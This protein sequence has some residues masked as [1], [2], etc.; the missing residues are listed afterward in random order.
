MRVSTRS[1][2]AG[3]LALSLAACAQT[4]APMSTGGAAQPDGATDYL[5]DGRGGAWSIT[6]LRGGDV[7]GVIG[8]QQQG[9]AVAIRAQPEGAAACALGIDRRAGTITGGPGCAGAISLVAGALGD[10]AVRAEIGPAV[11]SP[12]ADAT[13]VAYED[14]DRC[15]KTTNTVCIACVGSGFTDIWNC[16]A[17][18]YCLGF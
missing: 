18:A 8:W 10:P 4:A 5:V 11:A 7:V 2:G 14:G 3:I 6:A 17:C 16:G 1:I 13:D 12:G 15:G 9:D